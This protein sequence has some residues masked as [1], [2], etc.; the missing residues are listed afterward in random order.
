MVSKSLQILFVVIFIFAI[1][2][3][4]ILSKE[5]ERE[6]NGDGGGAGFFAIGANFINLDNLNNRLSAEGFSKFS[7]RFISLGGGGQ[8][9]IGNLI[10]GG[11]GHGLLQEN[12]ENP[13]Y[14]TNVSIG[15]GFFNLGYTLVS[16]N[17]VKLYPLL[18]IGGGGMSLEIQD[19]N[20]KSNFEELIK[21]PRTGTELSMGAFMLNFAL[22]FDYLLKLDKANEK[23]GVGSFIIGIRLGYTLS[24]I[25][26]NWVVYEKKIS[27]FPKTSLDGFSIRLH[28]GAGGFASK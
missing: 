25:K 2:C 7:S 26:S 20:P 3:T 16:T 9:Y 17:S 4:S 15:Y 23:S 27:N 5:K 11:E 12:T 19:M 13:N 14:S 1:P 6:K 10:I 28:I 22:G 21:N 8:A 24:A 18:G